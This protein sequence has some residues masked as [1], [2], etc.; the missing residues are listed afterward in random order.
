MHTVFTETSKNVDAF[1][2]SSFTVF[3]D[4]DA[5]PILKLLFSQKLQTSFTKDLALFLASDEKLS[6]LEVN[7]L[8]KIS[9]F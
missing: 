6:N 4:T 2:K 8:E 7:T 3:T 9:M 5:L 1:I